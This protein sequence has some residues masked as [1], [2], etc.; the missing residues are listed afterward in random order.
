[1]SGKQSKRR[2]FLM[3]NALYKDNKTKL[4]FL[5]SFK[6]YGLRV[7]E[8]RDNT[9]CN[10]LDL[11]AHKS[12]ALGWKAMLNSLTQTSCIIFQTRHIGKPHPAGKIWDLRQSV[13]L[14]FVFSD[15]LT[16]QISYHWYSYI[17]AFTTKSTEQPAA[18]ACKL[19]LH[20]CQDVQTEE[21]EGTLCVRT[22]KAGNM[23]DGRLAGKAGGE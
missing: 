20:K 7:S 18:H 22:E 9:L 1:M 10:M 23:W 12:F 8:I 2:K 13:G 21:E 4:I 15:C 16:K 19:W 17:T 5:I 6:I 11:T 14:F 3:S